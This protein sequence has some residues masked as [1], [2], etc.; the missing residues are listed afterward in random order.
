MDRRVSIGFWFDRRRH[1]YI[2]IEDHTRN[3]LE[4]PQRFRLGR[5]DVDAIRAAG[6][7]FEHQRQVA[8]PRVA[9][10]GFI[11]IRWTPRQGALGWEFHGD[12]TAALAVLR[13]FARRHGVGPAT[14]VTISDFSAGWTRTTTLR[15][16][17]YNLCIFH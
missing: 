9:S 7:V 12:P 11:R 15:E 10:R 14:V 3:A 5:A 6:P 16:M 1:R 13:R 17:T 2:E 8:I 4:T